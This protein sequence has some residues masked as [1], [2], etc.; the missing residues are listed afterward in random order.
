MVEHTHKS[1]VRS[2]VV[3]STRLQLQFS[4]ALASVKH[5]VA[6]VSPET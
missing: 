2:L 1:L 6:L 3:I 4:T 5:N